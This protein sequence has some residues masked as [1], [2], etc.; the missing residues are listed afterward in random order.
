[1]WGRIG[2]LAISAALTFSTVA[3]ARG[4]YVDGYT[5]KDGTYVAPH[6]RSAPDGNPY[7]N[8]ST[9][10]NTNPYTG[11]Q[12]TVDPERQ[13]RSG[14]YDTIA[15]E[16]ANPYRYQAPSYQTPSYGQPAPSYGTNP[17]SSFDN[18]PAPYGGRPP[19]YR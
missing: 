18:E 3:E 16:R 7:N 14:G 13:P 17:G 1:M 12:G 10:G 11:E 4:T 15:P 6:Y 9:R 2:F 19:R 8:Y 5:R